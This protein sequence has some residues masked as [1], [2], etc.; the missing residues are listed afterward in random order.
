MPLPAAVSPYSLYSCSTTL[1][2]P[3][4]TRAKG[5]SPNWLK[6]P[7]SWGHAGEGGLSVTS[8]WELEYMEVGTRG[9]LTYALHMARMHEKSRRRHMARWQEV[10]FKLMNIWVARECSP[11]TRTMATLCISLASGVPVRG[12]YFSPSLLTAH[13]AVT[14]DPRNVRGVR[15]CRILPDAVR[16]CQICKLNVQLKCPHALNIIVL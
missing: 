12:P 16:C 1:M 5:T 6:W 4:L 7:L 9:C 10:T 14:N 11:A 13:K 8:M 3:G 2:P 15:W